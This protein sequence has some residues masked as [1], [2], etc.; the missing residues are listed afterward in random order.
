MAR[1]VKGPFGGD[2]SFPAA[3]AGLT[4]YDT[5]IDDLPPLTAAIRQAWGIGAHPVANARSAAALFAA[6]YDLETR[7]TTL[8]S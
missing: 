7:V 5:P 8:E 1:P 6:V 4:I 2:A 3:M